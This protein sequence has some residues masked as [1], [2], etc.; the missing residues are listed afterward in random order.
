MDTIQVVGSHWQLFS[1]VISTTAVGEFHAIFW[2]EVYDGLL[3]STDYSTEKL[4]VNID[5]FSFSFLRFSG[6]NP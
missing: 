4:D 6:G 2:Y 1:L 5:I 3:L